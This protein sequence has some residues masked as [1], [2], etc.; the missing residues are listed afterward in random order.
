MPIRTRNMQ[1]S[2]FIIVLHKQNRI[3]D[4]QTLQIFDIPILRI[5]DYPFYLIVRF[6]L[7]QFEGLVGVDV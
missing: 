1:R 7:V 6:I 4:P 3:L 2:P 5:V